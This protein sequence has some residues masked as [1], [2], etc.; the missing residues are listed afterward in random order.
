[1]K[2]QKYK[3]V[4]V[5]PLGR[6]HFLAQARYRTSLNGN[7]VNSCVSH[8]HEILK[9]PQSQTSPANYSML[10]TTKLRR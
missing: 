4:K 6:S 2:S 3:R 5:T 10:R 1:M 9:L 8:H 7:P